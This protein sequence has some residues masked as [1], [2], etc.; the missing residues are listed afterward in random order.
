MLKTTIIL[1]GLLFSFSSFAKAAQ[2]KP[3]MYFDIGNIIIDTR[4]WKDVKY[5]PGAKEYI[6]SL[7]ER[8]Y[9]TNLLVNFVD[10]L[11][12]EKY[13]NCE[14]KFSGVARFIKALW[15]GAE[16]FDWTPYER[17]ILPPTDAQR[18]PRPYMFID[19]LKTSCPSS[20]LY[21]GESPEEIKTADFLGLATFQVF[22]NRADYLIDIDKIESHVKENFR[23]SYPANCEMDMPK[24][25][26]LTQ[27]EMQDIIANPRMPG[28]PTN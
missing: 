23:Y 3:V 1:S 28:E 20:I 15:K 27:E 24:E 4:D 11:K 13:A 16:P 6:E 10:K 17:I 7:K 2:K 18:K 14:Q 25:C 19:A 12:R 22:P 8:G 5:M 26:V 21:L 9:E